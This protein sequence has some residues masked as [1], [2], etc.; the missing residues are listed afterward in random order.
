MEGEERAGQDTFTSLEP[1]DL[2]L[3]PSTLPGAEAQG[4]V[5]WEGRGVGEDSNEKILQRN[6]KAQLAPQNDK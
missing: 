5:G 4:G 1:L 2:I 6:I 3:T